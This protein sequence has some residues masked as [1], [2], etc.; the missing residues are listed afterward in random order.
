MDIYWP[1]PRNLDVKDWQAI[2]AVGR[3]DATPELQR[4]ALEAIIKRIGRANDAKNFKEGSP[5]GT[6]FLLGRAYVGKCIQTVL[7]EPMP[8]EKA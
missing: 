5:D 8:E 1:S 7:A 2:K 3:G 4:L 6:A